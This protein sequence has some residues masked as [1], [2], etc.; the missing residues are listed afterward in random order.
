MIE[1]SELFW[2]CWYVYYCF[3]EW[4]YWVCGH[5]WWVRCNVCLVLWIVRFY[6][7]FFV[8]WWLVVFIYVFVRIRWHIDWL[9][10]FLQLLFFG[11]VGLWL[12]VFGLGLNYGGM[13]FE[14][15][16]DNYYMVYFFYIIS[17]LVSVVFWR[18]GFFFNYVV[19]LKQWWYLL[20]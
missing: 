8:C 19:L 1:F 3:L 7:K 11:L 12:Y 5:V 4:C 13:I 14:E 6:C 20:E 15:V 16:G 18:V 10:W 9:Y 2:W 17:C